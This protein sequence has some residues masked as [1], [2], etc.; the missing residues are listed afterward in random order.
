M[1]P[2]P[3]QAPASA[4]R[5]ER[6]ALAE[7]LLAVGPYAPTL[8][9]GWTTHDLAVHLVARERRPD[10]V[11]GVVA[12]R[13][14]AAARYAER[15]LDQYRER[16]YADLVAT[17]AAGPPAAVVPVDAL[18]NGVEYTIHH[19]DVLRAQ[20]EPRACQVPASAHQH[21]WWPARAMA[22]GR[23]RRSP[24]G[25]QVQVG[26]GALTFVARPGMPR[27]ILRIGVVDLLLLVSGR[28][29]HA[30]YQVDGLPEAVSRFTEW[31]H[32]CD[33]AY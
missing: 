3:A 5:A 27:V 7:A 30:T 26:D 11:A 25:V 32:G 14:P 2:A 29:A 12:S 9:A 1:T 15:V 18:M 8:C 22:T 31:L 13:L 6:A 17:F 10:L 20:P 16:E 24:V 19:E 28:G 21:L 33:W 4:A 23:L